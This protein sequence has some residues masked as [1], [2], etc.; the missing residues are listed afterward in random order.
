MYFVEKQRKSFIHRHFNMLKTIVVIFLDSPNILKFLGKKINMQL[1][2]LACLLILH[3]FTQI[4]RLQIALLN[5]E[6]SHTLYLRKE[7]Q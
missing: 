6:V 3:E 4:T 7:A 2:L 5:C 1:T